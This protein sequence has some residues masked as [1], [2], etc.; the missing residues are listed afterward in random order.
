MTFTAHN[1]S[2][3]L[4]L[5]GNLVLFSAVI[6]NDVVPFRSI[7]AGC[8][9]LRTAF[10]A[11][12]RRHHVPL[13][14]SVLFLFGKKERFLALNANGFDIRHRSYSYSFGIAFEAMAE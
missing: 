8:R 1:G 7:L 4:W 13:I 11:A 5:E 12:L 9:L 14:K 6:A 10:Q 3:D 2:A